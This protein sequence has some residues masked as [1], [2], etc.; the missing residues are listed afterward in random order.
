[1]KSKIF[2]VLLVHLSLLLAGNSCFGQ[3]QYYNNIK[4]W[5]IKGKVDSITQ[6]YFSVKRDSTQ[7]RRLD[8]KIVLF[9]DKSGFFTEDHYYLLEQDHDAKI[10]YRGLLK[11]V[12]SKDDKGNLTELIRYGVD[13]VAYTKEVY[14]FDPLKL[15]VEIKTYEQPS[16][17]L[18]VI[19]KKIFDKKGKIVETSSY[20]SSLQPI[21]KH[22]YKYN[23]K[24]HYNEDI[25]VNTKT[26]KEFKTVSTFDNDGNI[27]KQTNY[28]DL[29]EVS[30]TYDYSYLKYDEK[31]NW[32]QQ[33]S[34]F[35]GKLFKIEERVIA[36]RK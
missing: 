32:V 29:G 36:Y 28:N 20:N 16:N 27:I 6:S 11:N 33:N 30:S 21:N 24:D 4:L 26:L 2:N 15:L 3:F 25:E 22:L 13:G 23:E 18:R 5:N 17:E 12:N 19:T 1:M 8:S 9:F 31:H 34:F 14:S 10:T 35:N 7:A